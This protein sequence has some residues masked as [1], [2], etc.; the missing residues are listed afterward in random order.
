MKAEAIT[1]QVE[2]LLPTVLGHGFDYLVP[3]GLTLMPGDLVTVPF[4]RGDSLGVVWGKGI[5]NIPAG[6]IKAVRMRH[7]FPGL[8]QN[9]RDF[10]D[11]AAWYN[12]APKGAMLKMVLPIAEIDKEGRAHV[13]TAINDQN[14]HLANLSE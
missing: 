7:E 8:S 2:V 4:G 9:M 10:I 11:W 6:K 3:A 14:L 1:G 5:A 12:V 13:E